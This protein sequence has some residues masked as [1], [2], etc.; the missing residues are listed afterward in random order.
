METYEKKQGRFYKGASAFTVMVL[1]ASLSSLAHAELISTDTVNAIP[2][3]YASEPIHFTEDSNGKV[4]DGSIDYAVYAPGDFNLS[5]P[6]R[7]PSNGAQYVY[8]Y[9]LHNDAGT[10]TDYMKKL[11]VGLVGITGAANCKWIE[12]G[13][14]YSGDVEPTLQVKLI[15]S[16]NPT[17]A[18]WSFNPNT[19]I[20]PGSDSKMLIFTSPY[21]PTFQLASVL[22]QSLIN[23]NR[24]RRW[25]GRRRKCL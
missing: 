19:P 10:S 23:R 3:W 13:P 7:D 14:I 22:S 20:N 15:G 16:P 5:F 1:M 17:S 25:R 11:T 4:V 8:R 2:G 6:E 21:G 24:S 18:V 9:Q 12:P